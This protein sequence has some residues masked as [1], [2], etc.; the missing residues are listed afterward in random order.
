VDLRICVCID[1]CICRRV[2]VWILVVLVFSLSYCSLGSC[3]PSGYDLGPVPGADPCPGG[4]QEG[5]DLSLLDFGNDGK[6]GDRQCDNRGSEDDA[7]L[8]H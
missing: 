2:I 5:L 6:K 1:V 8:S 4:D 7:R 3:H